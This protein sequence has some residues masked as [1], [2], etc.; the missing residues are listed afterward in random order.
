MRFVSSR[1]LE[2]T[3]QSAGAGVKILERRCYMLPQN[4]SL[5]EIN[6]YRGHELC[7]CSQIISTNEVREGITDAAGY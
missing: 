7:L 4:G 5:G 3:L 6:D 2:I 1:A